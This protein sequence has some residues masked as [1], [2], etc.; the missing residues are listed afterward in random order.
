MIERL[1]ESSDDVS[2][3]GLITLLWAE[4]SRLVGGLGAMRRTSGYE[5]NN[6]LSSSLFTTVVLRG[7]T[8]TE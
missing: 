8:P 7:V 4:I 2:W 5:T 1:F 6:R 3:M